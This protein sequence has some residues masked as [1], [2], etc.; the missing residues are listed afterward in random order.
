MIPKSLPSDLIRGWRPVFG[1]DHAPRTHD[2]EKWRPVFGQDHANERMIPKSGVRFSDKIMRRKGKRSA[3]RR[4][5]PWPSLTLFPPPLWG[6]VG[7]GAAA[8]LAMTR[9]PFGAPLRR[10]PERANAPAQPR[11]RFTRTT[12]CGRYPRRHSRLSQAPGAPVIVPEGHGSGIWR[13]A[14]PQTAST[15]VMPGPPGSAVTNRARRNRTRSASG[16]VSRSVPHDSM[17]GMGCS[18]CHCG[19]EVKEFEFLSMNQD[20]SRRAFF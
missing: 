9:S 12:G 3:E 15:V 19:G 1:Q 13:F 7:R 2:P 10:L 14:F 5:Q 18:Y 6:R 16:I 17:S 8:R 4:I 11:P 20:V